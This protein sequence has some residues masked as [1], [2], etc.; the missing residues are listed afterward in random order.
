LTKHTART[1]RKT[2][3]RLLAA[4]L[5]LAL[6]TAFAPLASAGFAQKKTETATVG[7]YFTISTAYDHG[8]AIKNDGSLWAW[9]DAS[10]MSLGDGTNERHAQPIKIMDDTVSVRTGGT[11]GT[12]LTL[13]EDATV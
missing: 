12:T 4:L 1:Q 11:M 2:G 10:Y 13:K 3:T 7:E 5:A 8:F 6:M 9:G